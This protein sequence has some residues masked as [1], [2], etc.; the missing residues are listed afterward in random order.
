MKK[1]LCF[2]AAAALALTVTLGFSTAQPAMAHGCHGGYSRS[3]SYPVC[4]VENCSIGYTHLHDGAYYCGHSL[5]DG[6]DY[7]Q[8]CTVEGCTDTTAHYH[9]EVCYMG[10][11]ANDGHSGCY[12][13]A[14][15]HRG[16]CH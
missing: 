11:Y 8:L 6:H 4:N 13:G 5:N 16:G 2:T 1:K 7:H 10:H 14:G 12:A 9:D 15:R 3:N